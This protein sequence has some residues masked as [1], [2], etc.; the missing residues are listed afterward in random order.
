MASTHVNSNFKP[1]GVTS[2]TWDRQHPAL[3]CKLHNIL[4][5]NMIQMLYKTQH[6]R[7]PTAELLSSWYGKVVHRQTFVKSQDN[8]PVQDHSRL[9][10]YLL[11]LRQHPSFELAGVRHS[12]V[13]S[14]KFADFEAIVAILGEA[15]PAVFFVL[16]KENRELAGRGTTVGVRVLHAEPAND[17]PLH[18]K[19]RLQHMDKAYSPRPNKHGC[20]GFHTAH[21]V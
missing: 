17:L 16:Q 20:H 8:G 12:I 10:N 7:D 21:Q 9:V 3:Q 11:I 6:H 5:D 2:N 13:F 18:Y 1:Q 15:V 4:L 14:V 19:C